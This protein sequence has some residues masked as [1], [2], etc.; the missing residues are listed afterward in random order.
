MLRR[1]AG[2]GDAVRSIGAMA[3]PISVRFYLHASAIPCLAGR[4]LLAMPTYHAF[5]DGASAISR[6]FSAG[7]QLLQ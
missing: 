3:L 2:D 1:L 7:A 6:S 4:D 5:S